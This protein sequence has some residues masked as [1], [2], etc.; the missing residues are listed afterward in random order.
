[1]ENELAVVVSNDNENTNPIE[2]IIA[3]K[4]AG[5]NNVFIQWYDKDFE[6]DQ[7]KQVQLCKENNLNIIFAHLGYQNIN[8]IWTNEGDH[9]VDRYKKN[10]LDCHNLGINMVVLHAC[11]KSVAPSPNEI[12]LNR[13][14]QIVEYAANLDVKVAVENTRIKQ[15]IE[16]LLD[17]IK[18]DNFGLCFDLGHYHA[19]F[20]D[21]WDIS[22]YK[23]RVF[24]IHLHDNNGNDIDEHLLPYDGTLNWQNAINKINDLNYSGPITMEICYRKQY[25]NMNIKEF[26]LEGYKRGLKLID[27]NRKS[28]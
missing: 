15:N 20:N 11:S 1:M 17:N 21:D 4:Q 14:R 23:N 10:I 2:T 18:Q 6:V 3:I 25:T 5:F 28:N 9:F 13:F 19:H 27:E 12:G 22:K 8:D 16:Y 7:L 24:C 26:Y